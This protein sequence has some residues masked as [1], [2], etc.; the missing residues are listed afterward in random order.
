MRIRS[1]LAAA[2][3]LTVIAAGACSGDSSSATP[4]DAGGGD[5]G[6]APGACGALCATK[7]AI[8]AKCA[9]AADCQTNNCPSNACAPPGTC[10][11][12]IKNDDETDVDCGGSC[13]AKCAIGQ[14]C[15]VGGDCTTLHCGID[16]L[17]EATSCSDGI[18]D[19][20]E[21][22]VDCGGSCSTKC[23]PGQGCKVATD[24]RSSVCGSD[25]KCAAPTCS[26]GVKNGSETDVDCGGSC[27]QCP[28]G[29][30][31]GAPGDCTSGIC[32]GVC[33]AC[34]KGT[35]CATR[36]C[37]N[38]AC[39]TPTFQ[40]APSCAANPVC[41][42]AGCCTSDLVTGGTFARS[43]DGLQFLDNS[44]TATVGDFRLD[45][46]EVSVSRFRAFVNAYPGN[47]P[48]SG[49]G[50]NAN[51]PADPGWDVNLAQNL[52]ID[53]PGLITALASCGAESTW[54]TTAGLN[55]DKPINC[56]DWYMAYAF[57]AW[58]NARLPTEAEWNYA[59]AG[60]SQQRVYP[61]G[62]T[63]TPPITTYATASADGATNG[64]IA[65]VGSRGLTGA[66]L[67]GQL[68]LAGNVWE[69]VVDYWEVSY[70]GSGCANCAVLSPP[71][72]GA[73]PQ[74]VLRGGSI[75]AED[76]VL[77]PPPAGDGGQG[78]LPNQFP[79]VSYRG[80]VDGGNR[81]F[82]QGIRCARLK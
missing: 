50:A 21:T 9:T 40:T 62:S 25:G 48:A 67:Y 73:A 37:R 3:A 33:R 22:D 76:Y 36:V 38:T 75:N 61:W 39:V 56:V 79:P 70:G 77:L 65:A 34:L 55:E 29:K 6:C 43:Y 72:D 82:D 10:S 24:C 19:G 2:A 30:M 53:Q 35:D 54:T 4:A 63:F 17:C 51:N 20:D 31:C 5:G 66:G 44:K 52:P 11:D 57:C 59:A 81:F 1:L 78:G 74:R 80:R 68:D 13:P 23:A 7:C 41:G 12:G 69:W 27:P 16:G 8:G 42:G 45:R 32:T 28:N 64:V 58:D 26:D 14:G 60:G 15:K 47:R 71:G 46:F 18:K 49:D